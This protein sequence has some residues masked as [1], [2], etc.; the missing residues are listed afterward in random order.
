MLWYGEYAARYA[1]STGSSGEPN[2]TVAA[3]RVVETG[4]SDHVKRRRPAE[5]GLERIRRL[6]RGD[7]DEDA[8]VAVSARH[9]LVGR[10]VA[11]RDQPTGGGDEVVER[12]LPVGPDCRTVP[13]ASVLATAA[14]VGEGRA[15]P[16]SSQ[17]AWSGAY[18]GETSMLN[19]P[20]PLSRSGTGPSVPVGRTTS[21]ETFVPSIDS[22]QTC[23]VTTSLAA[24]APRGTN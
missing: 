16:F 13:L 15:P 18:H 3:R 1:P 17:A 2:S 5:N 20:Y 9:Q 6:Q 12:V 19:P 14:K 22:Y 4:E 8:A 23:S 24:S 7:C 21:I 10:R 11:V